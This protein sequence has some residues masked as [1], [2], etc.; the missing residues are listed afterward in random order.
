MW[1]AKTPIALQVAHHPHPPPPPSPPPLTPEARKFRG[2]EAWLPWWEPPHTPLS[3][4]RALAARS[5]FCSL[6]SVLWGGDSRPSLLWGV[7]KPLVPRNVRL[8]RRQGRRPGLQPLWLLQTSK[9][10]N[11]QASIVRPACGSTPSIC[12]KSVKSAVSLAVF[13][14]LCGPLCSSCQPRRVSPPQ[15]ACSSACRPAGALLFSVL[16]SLFTVLCSLF[17]VLWGGPAAPPAFCFLFSVFCS[18]RLL[19]LGWRCV[20]L[21]LQKGIPP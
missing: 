18:L 19:F 21:G 20:I 13:V 17:S 15:F 3:I 1:T 10:L 11:F 4:R 8:H 12:S 6:F 7:A 14:H 16:C 5:V 9:P 2:L